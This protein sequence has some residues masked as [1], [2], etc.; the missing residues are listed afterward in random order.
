[1]IG[2]L[3][4]IVYLAIIGLASA[5]HL[6]TTSPSIERRDDHQFSARNRTTLIQAKP[7]ETEEYIPLLYRL[8]HLRDNSLGEFGEEITPEYL[9]AIP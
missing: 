1:M 2:T 6:G 7:V 3:I 5:L 4:S 9:K 8:D